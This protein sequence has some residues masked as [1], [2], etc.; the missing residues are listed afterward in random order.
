MLSRL[1]ENASI[2]A[3]VLALVALFVAIGGVAGALPGKNT[4]NS[5]DIQRNAVRSSDIKDDKVTGKDVNENTLKIPTAALP[6]G[7]GATIGV[8]A[9]GNGGTLSRSTLA[10]V[11]VQKTSDLIT[12][13][14]PRNVANCVPVV[15]P[16]NQGIINLAQGAA[17]PNQIRLD[18]GS[19]SGDHNMIVV[20][21]D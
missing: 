6:A 12:Y 19:G 9:T 13:T 21:P 10:G 16:T 5:G 4:V 17:A 20:C 3:L 14:F 8:S 7:S 15:W 2:A 18:Q 11:T 1:K